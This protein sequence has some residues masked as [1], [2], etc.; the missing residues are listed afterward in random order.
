MY[1]VEEEKIIEQIKQLKK[2]KKAIIL[3]HNYQLLEVQKVADFVGD[4]LQLA[5]K[6]KEV[7]ADIIVCWR[8]FYGRNSK[9]AQS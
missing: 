1:N 5:Q 3:A 7:D 4:S 2:S 8:A 9:V 6:A